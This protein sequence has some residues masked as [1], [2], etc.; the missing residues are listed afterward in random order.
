MFD[1]ASAFVGSSNASWSHNAVTIRLNSLTCV[2]RTFQTVIDLCA[3]CVCLF[4]CLSFPFLSLSPP[5]PFTYKSTF[6]FRTIWLVLFAWTYVFFL[7]LLIL[8]WSD[9]LGV[10]SAQALRTNCV[11]HFSIMAGGTGPCK[12][13]CFGPGQAVYGCDWSNAG[14]AVC[15]RSLWM[16]FFFFF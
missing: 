10:F 5:L 3:V 11:C 9:T 8:L 13:A 2:L 1:L 7:L 4:V 12:R 6:V 14:T 15:S 16:L